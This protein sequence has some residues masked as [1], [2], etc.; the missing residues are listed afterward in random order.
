MRLIAAL[1]I[2]I[3]AGACSTESASPRD[4]PPPPEQNFLLSDGI[5]AKALNDLITAG[6]AWGG[7]FDDCRPY[8][9][10]RHYQTLG[11]DA[12][13]AKRCLA[14]AEDLAIRFHEAGYPAVR[15]IEFTDPEIWYKA[16]RGR[17]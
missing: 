14:L 8:W 13:R 10:A 17:P 6:G 2:A 3:L 15:A 5:T 16:G 9:K 4:P 11:Y 12:E 1:C 7:P